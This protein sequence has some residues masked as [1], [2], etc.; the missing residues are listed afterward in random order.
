MKRSWIW[1]GLGLFAVGVLSFRFLWSPDESD[2]DIAS[3][4]RLSDNGLEF[5]SFGSYINLR[6]TTT[7]V[8]RNSI[9][10]IGD[11]WHPGSPAM[12]IEAVR[13]SRLKVAKTE[14]VSLLHEKTGQKFGLDMNAWSTWLW[15]ERYQPHPEYPQFKSALYS[16]IDSRFAEYFRQTETARIRLDEIVWGGVLRDG[17]PPL[18]DPD[19]ISVTEATYLAD[20]NVVFGVELNG[21]AR[22]YPKRV[23]AWHEMFKDTIGGESVCGVY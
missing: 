9:A 6:A 13:L 15:N 22:C 18:K 17:I 2:S 21:D 16:T 8:V 11:G 3:V 4:S 19:M 1:M 5:T 10:E 23:L 20:D 14:V 7:Q 12:L